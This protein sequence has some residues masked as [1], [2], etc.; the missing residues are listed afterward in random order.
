MNKHQ[1]IFINDSH[2][3]REEF[4]REWTYWIGEGSMHSLNAFFT[5]ARIRDAFKELAM[6]CGVSFVEKNRESK[7]KLRIKFLKESDMPFGA[8]GVAY[9]SGKLYF[10]SSRDV[11]SHIAHLRIVEAI[12]QHEVMHVFGFKH[13]TR[14]GEIRPVGGCIMDPWLQYRYLCRR[15]VVSMQSQFGKPKQ[16]YVPR[17]RRDLGIRLQTLNHESK[18]LNEMRTNLI[19]KRDAQVAFKQW[20]EMLATQRTIMANLALIRNNNSLRVPLAQQWH[21]VRD[22]WHGAPSAHTV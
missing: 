17:E 5:R 15:E 18:R 6:Y 19:R 16:I 14:D 8:L 4:R 1:I 13:V 9:S 22:Y 20:P 10:N 12:T 21:R 2:P 3:E 11:N 7:A